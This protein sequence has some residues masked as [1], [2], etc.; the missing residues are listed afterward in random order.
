MK[1]ILIGRFQPLH[2]GH[3]KV[4]DT[5]RPEFDDFELV[6]G[7]ADKERT[8]DNPLSFDE[9]KKIIKACYPDLNV[10]PVEDESRDEE[11][12]K[13]WIQR[14]ET[15]T[16]ADKAV[17]QNP[18]VKRLVKEYSSME[19][20]EQEMHDPDIYSGTAVRRRIKAGE[21]W[22]YLVPKCAEEE[23]AEKLEEIKKSGVKY[24]FEPGWARK[25]AYHDT[26]DDS[27]EK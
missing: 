16:G 11:G 18:L 25:N 24:E 26:V 27:K 23:I 13:K 9:R 2:R 6:I 22:R 10:V 4:I 3:K 20:V 15:E 8:E 19:L 1:G 12:N 14:I 21:E 5:Y 7:S 17:S